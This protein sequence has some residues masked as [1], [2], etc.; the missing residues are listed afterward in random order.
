M[1]YWHSMHC[2]TE[3]IQ[4]VAPVKWRSL[5]GVMSVFWEAEGQHGA[6]AYYISP[7]PRIVIF[8]NDVSQQIRMSNEDKRFD[9]HSRPMTRAIYVPAGVPLWT[10]F[11]SAHRFSHLDVH[12]H[13]DRVLRFLSPSLGAS[14]ARSTLRRPVEIQ[15]VEAIETLAGLLVDEVS[16]PSKHAV[17]AENLV[18]SIVTG[19]LD[20][21]ANDGEQGSGRLTQAQMNKLVSHINARGDRRMNIAEMAATVGLSK[22]WFASAFKQTTGKTPLQWQ[23]A[24]RIERAQ[25]LLRESDMPVAE[26][27][28]QLGFSDQAHFTKAFRQFAGETPAA[29]RRMQEM[30]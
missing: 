23:L 9:R 16:N 2:K 15:D 1:S 22:S 27:A 11:T 25:T 21:P 19:L 26:I 18:G 6:S 10:S 7:D 14:V 8:F 28:A 20:I 13:K 3:G 24:Q 12:M 29:W 5:D 30:L 17:Y 4:A